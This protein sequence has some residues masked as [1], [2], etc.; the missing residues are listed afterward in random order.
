[1]LV[2]VGLPLLVLAGVLLAVSAS[3]RRAALRWLA[4]L[5]LAA[6]AAPLAIMLAALAPVFLRGLEL[7]RARRAEEARTEDEPA[8][9][10]QAQVRADTTLATSV[11]PKRSY[12]CARNDLAISSL[13]VGPCSPRN[14]RFLQ[15]LRWVRNLVSRPG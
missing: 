10:G 14:C 1:M 8:F 6:D 9:L 4:Y 2:H 7:R 12:A 13:A 3:R 15:A 5:L 11:D